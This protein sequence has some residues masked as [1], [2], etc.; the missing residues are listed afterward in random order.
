MGRIDSHLDV[1]RIPHEQLSD[2]RPG[3]PSSAVQKRVERV[4]EI[5]AT[6]FA[7]TTLLT[8]AD[9]DPKELRQH[10]ALTTHSSRPADPDLDPDHDGYPWTVVDTYHRDSA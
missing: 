4:R 2:R 8:N 6:R 1:P 9:M 3:K 5:Q 7:G 10:A